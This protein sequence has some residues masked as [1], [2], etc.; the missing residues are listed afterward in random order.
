MLFQVTGVGPKAFQQAAGFLRVYGSTEP[1]DATSVCFRSRV[2]GS[3]FRVQN[4]GCRVQG[5]GCRVPGSRFRVQGAGFRVQGSGLK[6]QGS[7]IRVQGAST[8]APNLSTRPRWCL[9]LSKSVHKVVLQK[10][11]PTQ[12]LQRILK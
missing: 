9:Y 7:G 4:A 11:I 1:L 10:S 12:I 3:G 6:F 8:G 2:Q 5:A